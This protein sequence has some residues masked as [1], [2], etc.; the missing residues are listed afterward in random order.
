MERSTAVQRLLLTTAILLFSISSYSQTNSSSDDST[1]SDVAVQGD[2][3]S[4]ALSYI[5]DYTRLSIGYDSEL[6]LY[7]EYFQV[8]TDKDFWTNCSMNWVH[9]YQITNKSFI[10]LM[11]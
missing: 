3:N 10:E 8:K 6:D 7:G 4:G 2:N 5:G 9:Q 11:G 1:S